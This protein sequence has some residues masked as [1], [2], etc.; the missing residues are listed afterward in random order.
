MVSRSGVYHNGLSCDAVIILLNERFPY[1]NYHM[2]YIYLT[3][4][5]LLQTPFTHRSSLM[6]INTIDRQ[7]RANYSSLVMFHLPANALLKYF[8]EII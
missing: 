3:D 6:S 5:L 2:T 8:H 7:M 4:Q 1:V